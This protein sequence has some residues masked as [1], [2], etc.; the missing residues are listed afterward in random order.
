MDDMERRCPR[1]GSLVTF[2]Y[3]RACEA[4]QQPCFKVLDCWWEQFDVVD[5]FRGRLSPEAFE[6]L[7]SPPPPNKVASLVALIRQA[8]ERC[9]K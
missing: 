9:K 3:C 5:Y 2:G 7:A 1:L 4:G 6:R 8:Q